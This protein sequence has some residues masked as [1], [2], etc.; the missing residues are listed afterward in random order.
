MIMAIHFFTWRFIIDILVITGDM[1]VFHLELQLFRLK[2]SLVCVNNI[3][4]LFSY[5]MY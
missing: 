4:T 5:L 1:D 3:Y 2:I